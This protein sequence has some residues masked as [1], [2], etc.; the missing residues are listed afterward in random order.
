[1]DP[2]APPDDAR[3][4]AWEDDDLP[5]PS[6]PSPSPEPEGRLDIELPWWSIAEDREKRYGWG[7]GVGCVDTREVRFL[8]VQLTQTDRVMHFPA[9]L[10]L[11]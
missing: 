2:A 3:A 10:T 11:L 4:P 1:M 5:S 6:A 7:E 9:L 8:V